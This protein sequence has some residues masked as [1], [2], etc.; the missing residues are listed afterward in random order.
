MELVFTK[1][2]W[3]FAFDFCWYTHMYVVHSMVGS[4]Q[5]RRSAYFDSVQ[6]Q[7][8]LRLVKQG[9]YPTLRACSARL[10]LATQLQGRRNPRK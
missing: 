3:C 1:V 2:I 10:V 9:H 7:E 5:V 6:Y 8:P 4:S